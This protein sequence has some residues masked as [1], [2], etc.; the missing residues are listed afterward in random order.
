MSAHVVLLHGLGRTSASMRKVRRALE[1]AGL[2]THSWAYPSRHHRL[3]GHVEAFRQWLSDQDFDGPVHFVGHSLGGLIIRGTLATDPPVAVGKIVMIA[4]PNQGAGVVTRHGN[5]RF[6]RLVFG[7]PLEDLSESSEALKTLG[8]PEAKIGIIAGIQ[9]FHFFN[10][11]S[12]VNL[13]H[14]S[15]HEHDGTVE[16]HNTYLAQASDTIAIDAH[17]TFICDHPEVIK[18]TLYFIANGHFFKTGPDPND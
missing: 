6:S 9:P 3:Q 10:P 11:I 5:N 1:Q 17:H 7:Q 16:I 13:F 4:T 8:V 12:W 14:I 15:G 2:K 18:Q